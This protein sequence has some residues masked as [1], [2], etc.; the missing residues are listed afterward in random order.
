MATA[1]ASAGKQRPHRHRNASGRLQAWRRAAGRIWRILNAAPPVVRFIAVASVALAIF[2]A[3]NLA[4]QVIRK[5]SELFFPVSGALDKLPAETWHQYGPFF[6]EYSTA[7]ITPELLAAL[8]QIEAAGNPV[9]RTYWRWRLAAN[10]FAIYRPASSSVGMFQM[11]DPA[12]AEARHYCIRHHTVVESGG[13]WG[14]CWF[15]GFYMRVLPSHAI[16]LTAVFL[17]RATAAV[18]ERDHIQ[19]ASPEQRQDLATVTH[20]CGAGPASDFARNGFRLAPEARCGDQDAATY[21][22]HVRTMRKRFL[23]LAAEE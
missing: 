13:D 23:S 2:S 7:S 16:E 10:P 14:S 19:S 20:L 4:Y 15:D 12:F 17:D 6:R 11:T 8:A 5:P 18:L 9:A 3:V 1:R 21:L 22:A